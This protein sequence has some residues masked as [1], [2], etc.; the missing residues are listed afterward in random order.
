MLELIYPR[1]QSIARSRSLFNLYD[2]AIKS[3]DDHIAFNL[4]RS[5]SLTP[6]GIVLLAATVRE[7]QRQ[8]KRCSYRKPDDEGFHGF[9][10][11]IGFH[12]FFGLNDRGPTAD[13]IKTGTIQLKKIRGIDTMWI[14]NMTEIFDYHLSISRR[15]KDSL[16]MSLIEMMTNIVDHSGVDESLVC[17]WTYPPKAQL[18]VCIADTG[19]GILRSLKTS[20]EFSKLKNDYKAIRKSVENG[21]SCRP[22]RA[23][24][25]L[26]HITRFLEVN[27]GQL[28][29]I[30]G[31]GKVFWKF[32]RGEILDQKMPTPFD[33][34]IVKLII[35]IDKEGFYFFADEKDY[36]F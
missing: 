1:Q 24:L 4:S 5:K 28:C 31:E 16:R 13:S 15:V 10:S 36:L 2:Q 17:A 7:C 3:D 34:T 30:S 29:I 8:G 6:L 26:N 23:G 14:E 35:N 18:R 9:L 11:E 27:E 25:G 20:S 21:V 33:G 22:G 32:D 12:S 19:K